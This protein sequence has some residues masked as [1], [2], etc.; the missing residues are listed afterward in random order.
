[1]CES[2]SLY[3]TYFDALSSSHEFFV[4]FGHIIGD[5]K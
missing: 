3:L 2:S 4:S 1:M 5:E